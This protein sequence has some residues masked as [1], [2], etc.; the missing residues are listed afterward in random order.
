MRDNGERILDM[1][2]AIG[3]I[4]RYAEKGREAF[5][6]NELIQ[7]WIVHHLGILGEAAAKLGTEFSSIYPQ[8]PWPQIVSM[9]NILIHEYFGINLDEVWQVVIKD[10]P[11]LKRQLLKINNQLKKA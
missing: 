8:V 10:L 4:E 1:L 11:E 3:Q 7:I 9:R 5:Y 6:D 2:D